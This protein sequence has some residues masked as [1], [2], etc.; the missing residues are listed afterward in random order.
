MSVP[1]S[2]RRPLTVVALVALA[3]LALL[4]VSTA[5]ADA[6]SSHARH[7]TRHGNASSHG[8][9]HRRA[10]ASGLGQLSGLLPRNHLTT[11]SALRVDLNRETVRLPLYRGRSPVPGAPGQ[12]ETV[13]FVLLDASDSGLAHDLGVNYAPKLANLA[14]SCSECVQTV[15][16]DRPAPS[17]NRFGQANVDFAGAPDFGPTRVAKPGPDGFPLADFQPGA[18]AGPGYSPF[19]R[20]AG[21]SVV[22]NAPIVA[23]GDHPSDVVHHT[24][25]ADRALGIHLA[26]NSPQGQFL[27]SYVDMLFVK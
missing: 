11:E 24:D 17:E 14:I 5:R 15:T 3:F 21:S 26:G 10:K 27:E 6:R 20:I 2:S 12:T 8:R 23:V 4:A 9:R 25:T 18:V 13:W 1:A 19:I 22:Y 7:G 16:L